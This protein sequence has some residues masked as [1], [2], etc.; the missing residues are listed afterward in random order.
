M[1]RP[2]RRHDRRQLGLVGGTD[3]TD[4]QVQPGRR[5][6]RG[7]LDS[8]E[9]RRIRDPLEAEVAA[10][11]VASVWAPG[12][13]DDADDLVEVATAMVTE[14]AALRRTDALVLLAS[15]AAVA[16][17][18][19]ATQARG[20]ALAMEDAGIRAPRWLSLV[21]RAEVTAAWRMHHVLGDGDNLLLGCRHPDGS[22]H[23]LVVYIDHNL[24][25][26]LKDAFPADPPDEVLALF[27]EAADA[28]PDVVV[29]TIELD[30]AAARITNALELTDITF[31]PIESED[32]P[33]IR[34]LLD[35]RL[36]TMPPGGQ[37]PEVPEL[38]EAEQDALVGDFLASAEGAAWAG[39]DDAALIAEQLVRF[40]C[41]YGDGR[42][43]RW[44]GPVVE[45]LLTDWFP[46]KVVADADLYDKVPDVLADWV[47]FAGDR[48]GLRQ[49]H[50][51][52]TLAAV[53]AFTG[54]F[55]ELVGDAPEVDESWFPLLPAGLDALV[56]DGPDHSIDPDEEVLP[57]PIAWQHIPGALR[58]RVATIVDLCDAAC[59]RALDPEYQEL[60]RRLVARLARKRPSPLAR[61]R[62]EIWAGGVL[63]ALGQVNYLFSQQATIHRTGD[64]LA[65]A[66]GAKTKTIAAKATLVRDAI[67]LREFDPEFTRLELQRMGPMLARMKLRY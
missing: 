62:P 35:A 24:G 17:E 40:R 47:R 6:A 60:A 12:P 55:E 20:A 54:E 8:L 36:A 23:S 51:D 2:G 3:V 9:M 30:E 64:E 63:Y 41:E 67:D 33:A 14:I 31:P 50:V 26:L 7:L 49:V 44:S 42:P 16:A 53:A 48:R 22:E 38:S 45:L 65:D 59:D 27:E 58:D 32:Y 29:D 39:D 1:R 66:V 52:E 15:L 43:L 19:V 25:T 37:V 4:Q 56:D 28:D 5:W 34:P 61:G 57:A 11:L 18:P 46:R 21:G 13:F 10:S